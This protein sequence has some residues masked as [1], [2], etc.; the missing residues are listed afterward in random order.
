MD[1]NN[2]KTILPFF[3]KSFK[4]NLPEPLK[5]TIAF[6]LCTTLQ[7]GILILTTPVIT[8]L[9]TTEEYGY[10]TLFISWQRIL[11]V[12]STLTLDG[13]IISQAIVK[14]GTD[15]DGFVSAMTGYMRFS[16]GLLI[17]LLA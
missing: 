9:L 14:N 2:K 12:F 17:K 8:R 4:S 10:Y 15:R 3:N 16:H 5:A 7:K 11:A 6:A 13:S 1:Q